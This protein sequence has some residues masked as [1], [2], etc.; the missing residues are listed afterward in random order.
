MSE[1]RLPRR[2]G[3]SIGAVVAGIFAGAILSLGTDGVLHVVE[4]F[5]P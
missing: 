2:I 3:R 4:V 1:L 5:P